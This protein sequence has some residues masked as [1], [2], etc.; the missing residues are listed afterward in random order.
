MAQLLIEMDQAPSD[1]DMVAY[2]LGR[3]FDRLDPLERRT[4]QALAIYRRPVLPAAVDYLLGQYLD[5]YQSEPTLRRLLGRRMIRQDSDRFYLPPSPDGEL[6][7]G[8]IPRGAEA[9]RELDP[10]PLTL[11]ALL[12]RAAGYYEGA[13]KRR[14][15]RIDDLS[16]V[17]AEID[18]RMR[19][20]D[21]RTALRRIHEI[22]QAYLRSW[23]QSDAVAP[24]RAQL[25]GK[26]GDPELELHNLSRLA[27]ARQQQENLREAMDL[28]TE[29]LRLAR[30]I[31]DR[32]DETRIQIE[33]GGAHI[34]NGDIA[35]AIPLYQRALRGARKPMRL[36]QAMAREGLMR[37]L[38]EIGQ[39][40]QALEHSAAVLSAVDALSDN[41]G[42]VLRAEV[43]LQAGRIRLQL[44]QTEEALEQ[45]K[46]GQQLARRLRQN[47]LEGLCLDSEAQALID[48]GHP[49]QAIQTAADAVALGALIRSPQLS[50]AANTTLALA[51]LSS[52][53]LDAACTA[54]DS[55]ARYR[56]SR[57]ALGAFAVQGITAFRNGQQEKAR[58]A[59]L[60]AHVQAE[61]L[62]RRERRSFQVLDTD[63]LVRCGLALC[64]DR[65]QFDHA[66]RVYR[67]ARAVTSA[68]GAVRRSVRLLDELGRGGDRE[69]LAAAR[70]AAAGP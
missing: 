32:D 16:A 49:A 70:L 40:R 10:P 23:G 67:A 19:G 68:P 27:A 15:E 4:L 21:Y 60:D 48:I 28:L 8:G 1:Q 47:L 3:V 66:V 65:D 69:A 7:L 9:D 26:L 62:L 41:D 25:I 44:G 50:R 52:G 6:V 55:A 59:F 53:H 63:A 42:E 36:E 13:R 5:G 37:C 51:H 35:K 61:V 2:L 33:L 43:L 11:F 45:L 24:W 14:V 46:N 30:R 29:A 57:R 22:D 58:L 31:G 34:D 17:F 54:A 39:F 12:H 56:R 18:L 20:G 64:G 38:G